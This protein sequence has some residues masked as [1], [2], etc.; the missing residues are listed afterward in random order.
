MA[1]LSDFQK[2]IAEMI[3]DFGDT[4][5]YYHQKGNNPYDASDTSMGTYDPT[6]GTFTADVNQFSVKGILMDLQLKQNGMGVQSGTM[7]QEGDK[8]LYLVPSA[9]M[10]ETT[11]P[12]GLYTE[13]V[14]ADRVKVGAV[15]YKIF[16]VKAL[17]PTGT[18]AILYE[19]YLRR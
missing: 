11:T 2:A 14:A 7:I 8:V 17:D 18:G 12:A 19:F 3:A 6:T 10:L 13:N 9:D 1:D 4:V 16:N 15:D 5:T